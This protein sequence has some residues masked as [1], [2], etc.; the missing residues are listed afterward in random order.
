MNSRYPW[1][2]VIIFFDTPGGVGNKKTPVIR[3]EGGKKIAC[4][5]KSS[6]E[7]EVVWFYHI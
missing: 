5:T 6:D 2:M 3:R 4:C 1:A 7:C